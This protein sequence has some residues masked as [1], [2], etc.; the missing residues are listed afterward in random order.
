M[1]M[2][3]SFSQDGPEWYKEE[4]IGGAKGSNALENQFGW[5][6]ATG[7]DHSGPPRAFPTNRSEMT[8]V[9]QQDT[10]GQP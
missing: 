8:D 3:E 5:E 4:P 6:I 1:P 2:G 7:V 10:N 9:L